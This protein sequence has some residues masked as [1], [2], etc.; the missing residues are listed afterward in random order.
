[1]TLQSDNASATLPHYLFRLESSLGNI[2]LTTFPLEWEE[3]TLEINRRLDAGG[4]FSMF[5]IES[6]TFI[7]EGASLLKKLWAAKEMLAE[8]TLKIKYLK[9]STL[10][11]V[12]FPTSYSLKFI[13]YKIVK[14]GSVAIGVN[15]NAEQSGALDKFDNRRGTVVDLTKTTSIG[16]FNIV[17]YSD[18]LK[19][20]AIPVISA[21][22][23]ADFEQSVV[24]NYVQNVADTY[25]VYF[26]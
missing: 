11:Y 5:N 19:D 24:Q 8:C 1:M 23:T 12:E 9:K 14:V 21:F 2:D 22:R 4:V 10:Q 3:G 7:K 17:D 16:G 13:S 26:P 25:F 20:L 18:L 6:L 15:I